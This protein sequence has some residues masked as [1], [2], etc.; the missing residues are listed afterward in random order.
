MYRPETGCDSC[1]IYKD[2]HP[3]DEREL[4]VLI[5]DAVWTIKIGN[6]DVTAAQLFNV[7]VGFEKKDSSRP[8]LSEERAARSRSKLQRLQ[9][10]YCKS[11]LMSRWTRYLDS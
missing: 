3:D 10:L 1:R 11:T 7:T 6:M 2:R 9:A 8:G 4:Y 5:V